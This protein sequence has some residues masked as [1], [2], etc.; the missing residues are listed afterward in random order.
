MK[1]L[2]FLPLIFLVLIVS[3][4]KDV[5]MPDNAL[6]PAMAR[7]SLYYIMKEWYYW[8]NLMPEVT[9]VTKE[10]YNDPY[11]LLEAMRYKTLD[12]WSFVTDYD[13]FNA[14][15]QGTFVGHGFRIGLDDS[16]NARIAMIY[17]KSPLFTNGVRRGWI[18]QKIDGVDVAPLLKSEDG[19]AYSDLIG[20]GVS[21]ITHIFLFK[22][23]DGTEVT[24]PST[25]TSFTVNSVLLYETLQ[26]SSGLTGHL[27]FESFITPSSD[28]LA[29]AFAFFKAN[30]IKDLILDLRYNSGGYL[31]IAQTLASYIAGNSYKGTVF[32]KLQYNNKHPEENTNFLFQNTDYSLALPRIVVITTRATASA[33]EAVM[34]GLKPCVNVVSIGDAT[35]GKPTGMN[36][37]PIGKKYW[38]W[39]VTFKMVN[40]N[41]EGDYFDGIYPAKTLP[42][43]I[44]HDFSDREEVC[45]KE[46]IHYL[47]TGSVSTKGGPPFKHSPQFSEKPEWMNN[48]FVLEK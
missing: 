45:L 19:T 28:E 6:T 40:Q 37:W 11:E 30:N 35:N 36:G 34:N 38:M 18:V 14:E 22:R 3:C 5:V 46:A 41:N 33:S 26:L 21:G 10:N 8:Y 44:T 15:M 42:D 24:I 12:R 25:K 31:Y 23:P 2:L 29:T 9:E 16:D 4:K 17:S 43:D 47:E 32:A 39:P 13:E 48:A 7:D 20:P 1:K 27:V